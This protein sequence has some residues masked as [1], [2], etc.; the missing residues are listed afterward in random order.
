MTTKTKVIQ[1]GS[2]TAVFEK[3]Q[4]IIQGALFKDEVA[5]V[6]GKWKS[7]KKKWKPEAMVVIDGEYYAYTVKKDKWRRE[8][9]DPF[10]LSEK[11]K[12]GL[13]KDL[14]NLKKLIQ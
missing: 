13:K 6:V 9:W 1:S 8:Y 14:L 2:F 4:G 11:Q 7:D 5:L 3:K 10:T 12:E